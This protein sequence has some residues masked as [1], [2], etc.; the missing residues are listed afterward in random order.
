MIGAFPPQKVGNKFRCYQCDKLKTVMW[1][2]TCN[3]CR[4]KNEQAAKLLKATQALSADMVP[5]SRV[6]AMDEEIEALKARLA[7]VQR[8][9]GAEIERLQGM[10]RERLRGNATAPDWDGRVR[11][12]LG[13]LK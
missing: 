2:D 9:A 7:N 12:A 1:G 4:E 3:E 10:V 5:R 8:D 11:R 13:G 6:V